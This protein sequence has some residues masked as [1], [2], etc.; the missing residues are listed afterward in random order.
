[1]AGLLVKGR[2]P[3]FRGKRPRMLAAV[4]GQGSK[5]SVT[6]P[7]PLPTRAI[8]PEGAI[9]AT[10]PGPKALRSA[11]IR[12]CCS[13]VK[14]AIDGAKP[15]P[16][17]AA[18]PD[19]DAASR[20]AWFGRQHGRTSSFP[21]ERSGMI[22]CPPDFVALW[23]AG[24]VWWFFDIVGLDEG[25]CGRRSPVRGSLGSGY[26]LIKSLP[27]MSFVSITFDSAGIGS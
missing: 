9:C 8:T 14:K 20:Q 16:Y 21:M 27:C 4:I 13:Y 10:R 3:E 26:R 18:S 23:V 2:I 24:L 7:G 19:G 12:R 11:E 1:M 5:E 22:G 25:T 6:P 15:P 17:M